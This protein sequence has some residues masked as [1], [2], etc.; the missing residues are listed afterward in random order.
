MDGRDPLPSKFRPF[1]S[2]FSLLPPLLLS[3]TFIIERQRDT[4]HEQ[5]K[6]RERH[7]HRFRSRLQALSCQHR[8]RRGAQTHQLRDHDLSRSWL[9]NRLSH[10]GAPKFRH[11]CELTPKVTEPHLCPYAQVRDGRKSGPWLGKHPPSLP[12][13]CRCA[14]SSLCA[15]GPGC[16]C[17]EYRR[18]LV[19]GALMSSTAVTSGWEARAGAEEGQEPSRGERGP[20]RLLGECGLFLSSPLKSSKN[21]FKQ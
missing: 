5:V 12:V 20:A 10:P 15:S 11:F 9:P 6:G 17:P 18:E 13:C 1:F 14:Y 21:N 3:L 2:F 19:S 16:E 7:R 4:E 8:A